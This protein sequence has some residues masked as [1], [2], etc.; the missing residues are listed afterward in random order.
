MLKTTAKRNETRGTK[1]CA[2]PEQPAPETFA[3]AIMDVD[4]FDRG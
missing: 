2:P 3:K 1:L 4:A